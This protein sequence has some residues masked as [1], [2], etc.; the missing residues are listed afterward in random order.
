MLH[1]IGGTLSAHSGY[2][3]Y[4]RRDEAGNNAAKVLLYSQYI[5]GTLSTR[6]AVACCVTTGD[7]AANPKRLL[8]NGWAYRRVVQ[9]IGGTCRVL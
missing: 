5:V 9:C 3:E 6:S 8:Q 2:S 1:T 4:S 7:S